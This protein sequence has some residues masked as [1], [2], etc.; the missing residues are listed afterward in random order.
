MLDVRD[1]YPLQLSELT[2][3]VPNFD[4]TLRTIIFGHGGTHIYV[5]ETGFFAHLEGKAMEK[6]HPLNRVSQ[7]CIGVD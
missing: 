5:F 3:A 2:S 4:Q 1:D 7:M 6:D